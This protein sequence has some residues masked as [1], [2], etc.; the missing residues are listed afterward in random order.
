MK[1]WP[2]TDPPWLTGIPVVLFALFFGLRI[3]GYVNWQWWVIASPLWGAVVL[4]GLCIAFF[5]IVFA[6]AWKD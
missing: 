3:F 4:F 5:G 6:M 1:W 2:L